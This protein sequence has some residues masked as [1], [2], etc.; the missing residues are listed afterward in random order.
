MSVR[1]RIFG[2]SKIQSSQHLRQLCRKRQGIALPRMSAN[3][4]RAL[5]IDSGKQSLA[6]YWTGAQ[7]SAM[8][9]KELL[10]SKLGR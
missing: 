9:A 4:T 3:P 6:V 7:Y 1:M 2:V 10:A 8:K 5:L